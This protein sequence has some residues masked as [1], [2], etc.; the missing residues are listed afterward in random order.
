MSAGSPGAILIGNPLY[1]EALEMRSGGATFKSIAG[2]LGV[3]RAR[4]RYLVYKGKELTLRAQARTSACLSVRARYALGRF[5]PDL[6]NDAVTPEQASTLSFVDLIQIPNCGR[7]SVDEIADWLSAN[8]LEMRDRPE[9]KYT[10]MPGWRPVDTAPSNTSILVAC[11]DQQDD[12]WSIWIASFETR[13]VKTPYWLI[14][15]YDGF[16]DISDADDDY[17][18]ELHIPVRFWMPLPAVPVLDD[19]RHT[20]RRHN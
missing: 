18:G 3:S 11:K 19:T 9:K 14:A 4:A 6:S 16:I 17:H 10:T 7:R 20:D 15:G 12:D 13:R 2:K 8:G 1:G 5:F